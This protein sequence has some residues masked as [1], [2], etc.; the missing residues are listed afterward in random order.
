MAQA[1]VEL[2][3]T[4]FPEAVQE[5]YSR[6]GDETVVVDPA[7]WLDPGDIPIQRVEVPDWRQLRVGPVMAAFETSL[8]MAVAG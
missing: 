8:K 5:T 6:H 1:L 3:Q 7:R 4:K 2:L